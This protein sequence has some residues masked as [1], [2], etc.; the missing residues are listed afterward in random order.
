MTMFEDSFLGKVSKGANDMWRLHKNSCELLLQIS[1]PLENFLT[2]MFVTKIVI[3]TIIFL[4]KSQVYTCWYFLVP[5]RVYA[6]RSSYE[7]SEHT[8]KQAQLEEIKAPIVGNVD[9]D[10][11]GWCLIVRIVVNDES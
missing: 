10:V 3:S 8:P 9:I 2:I 1:V 11:I 5:M 7:I 6:K 4:V